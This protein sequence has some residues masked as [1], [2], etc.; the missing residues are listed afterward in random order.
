MH[1]SANG[2]KCE[3]RLVSWYKAE[4]TR[5]GEHSWIECMGWAIDAANGCD[6]S[7][8]VWRAS[9]YRAAMGAREPKIE[10][11]VIDGLGR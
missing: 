10:T 6:R 5:I 1:Q 8:I 7:I 9:D 3:C 2:T 4:C 11:E